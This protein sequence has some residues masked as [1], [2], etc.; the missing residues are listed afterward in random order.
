MITKQ[1]AKA[2]LSFCCLQE[3]RHRGTGSKIISLDTGEQYTFIWCGQKKRRDA[4]V[5]VLIKKC[6]EI[7]F[8]EPDII[9]PRIMAV[10]MQ[11]KG[12]SIRLINVYSPTNCSGSDNQKD[13]FYRTIRKACNKKSVHQKLIVTGDFNATT[14]ISLKNCCFDGKQVLED[15]LCNDNGFRIKRLC[16]EQQ[17]CMTQTYFDHPLEER[18]TWYCENKTTKKVID[19]VLMERYI[20]QFVQGCSV[21]SQ[22]DFGSDHRL[23]LTEMNTPST[24]RARKSLI[25][26]KLIQKPDP[27]SLAVKEVKQLLRRQ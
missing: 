14:S 8:D 5:G 24:R 23:L 6:R 3:V 17:L 27:K 9:D 7:T 10:N 21:K 13:V 2:E 12:F 11:I 19:Y 18:Y 4:G 25:K 16:R 26:Q 15:D 20:Q 22:M 1:V